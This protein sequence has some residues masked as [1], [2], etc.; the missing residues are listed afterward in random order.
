MLTETP[1]ALTPLC[2]VP[3]GSVLSLRLDCAGYGISQTNS[4][5]DGSSTPRR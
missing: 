3:A 1:P 2:V 4:L 5:D